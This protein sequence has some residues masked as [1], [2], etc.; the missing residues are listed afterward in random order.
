MTSQ[1]TTGAQVD[2]EARTEG[3]TEA[4]AEA[5]TIRSVLVANRGEIARRVFATCREQGIETV[6]VF[7]DPDEGLP[8]VAEADKTVRLPGKSAAET[9]LDGPAIIE[10]AHRTGADAIHPGYG[11]LSENAE[12][13]RAVMDAGLTWI[14]PSPEAIESMGSKVRSKELMDAAGVP[15][16]TNMEPDSIT[17]ADLPVLVKA[18]AGGGGRGM[19]VADSMDA[20]AETIESAKREAQ[21][22]FGDSTVFCERYIPAGHHV[23]VQVVGDMHGNVWAVGERECSIQRRHQKVVEEAPAP[24][25]E[26]HG[27]ELRDRLFQAAKDAATRIGYVGAGTVEFLADSNGE[28]FFLE[29]N[30][31]LQVEHPVTESV[32]GVDLVALQ[33]HVAQ[34]GELVGEPP[35][36]TGHSIEVRLYAEDPAEGWKPQSGPVHRF[37]VPGVDERFSTVRARRAVDNSGASI[38]LDAAYVDEAAFDGGAS[39]GAS[40]NT[41]TEISPFYDPMIAKIISTADTRTRAATHLADALAR[42]DWDGP[43]VN[44]DLLV[45]ILRSDAFVQGNTDTNF[46]NE[47]EDVF[48]PVVSDHHI[49]IAA[50]AAALALAATVERD[51][52][53]TASGHIVPQSATELT[54]EESL[55]RDIAQRNPR[56]HIGRFRLFADQ[57]S[58]RTFVTETGA[59]VAVATSQRRGTWVV[60]NSEVDIAVK[61]ARPER[62]VL[63]IDGVR[64]AYSVRVQGRRVTVNSSGASVVLVEAERFTD[65]A[66]VAAPGSLLAPMPGVVSSVHVNVGDAVT[67]GQAL[68]TMEAMKMEHTIHAD[69]DG[70]L[71]ELPVSVGNQVEAGALLAVIEVEDNE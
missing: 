26:R 36:Q 4:R 64:T 42:M 22:A 60:E 6:A 29:M 49:Q 50:T 5:R 33:L 8:F 47:H 58:A 31:R 63:E 68:L 1:M 15:I 23:E 37:D 9:Y 41:G 53:T 48:S 69:A 51:Q 34:G 46:L 32:T 13:A 38:R 54:G 70:S 57:P 28:F 61:E 43:T 52:V 18:S 66:L 11:F 17:E 3:H 7:S 65:P 39:G 27:Q 10:A 24:L 16:L 30:T 59:E 19:R 25:V 20:L 62:V 56:P 67:T 71:K 40:A 2:A 21:S 44:R 45:Q 55:A 35:A 12:F 14:G